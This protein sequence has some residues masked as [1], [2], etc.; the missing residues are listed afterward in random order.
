[1]L[2]RHRDRPFARGEHRRGAYDSGNT[3]ARIQFVHMKINDISNSVSSASTG[4]AKVAC[5]TLVFRI[6]AVV[7]LPCML[8][9]NLDRFCLGL[10]LQTGL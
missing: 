8:K 4:L 5:F 2:S 3:I 6:E 1:M 9:P 7:P 10:Q